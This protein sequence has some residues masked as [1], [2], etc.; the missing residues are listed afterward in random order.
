MGVLPAESAAAP[1]LWHQNSVEAV[2]RDRVPQV[3][4]ER[5]GLGG[6]EHV[7]VELFGEQPVAGLGDEGAFLGH[8]SPSPR[9]MTPRM[10]SV[11]PPR[12][13]KDTQ[14]CCT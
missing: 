1:I 14:A 3:L 9:A 10:I 4:W 6:R 5:A 7:L 2:L 8:R 11:V 12:R 13:E